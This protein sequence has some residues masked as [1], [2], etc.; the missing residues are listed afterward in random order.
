MSYCPDISKNMRPAQTTN[1][2][3]LKTNLQ[4]L[5]FQL[6]TL[7]ILNLL[8]NKIEIISNTMKISLFCQQ[9]FHFIIN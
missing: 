2:L 9:N 3:I 6:F 5:V 8:N 4:N 7:Q 1:P